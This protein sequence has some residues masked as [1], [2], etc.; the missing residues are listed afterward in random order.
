M[1]KLEWNNWDVE[2]FNFWQNHY[3][4]DKD[5]NSKTLWMKDK[6]KETEDWLYKSYIDVS[7][8]NYFDEFVKEIES[9]ITNIWKKT[10]YDAEISFIYND[11]LTINNF[12]DLSIYLKILIDNNILK[13]SINNSN[14]SEIVLFIDN[15][16]L[17]DFE[18]K[19]EL[20]SLVWYRERQ[21]VYFLWIK[22][23]QKDY[24]FHTNFP[25]ITIRSWDDYT[26]YKVKSILEW[27]N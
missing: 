12:T 21:I 18:E 3:I 9:H 2:P 24:I 8:E 4:F 10:E 17:L 14:N 6:I 20:N 1:N 11:W 16:D 25:S 23:E 13:K 5:W 27:K 26:I 7:R 22:W 15:C 19:K